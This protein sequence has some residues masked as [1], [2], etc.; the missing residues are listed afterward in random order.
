MLHFLLARTARWSCICLNNR[1]RHRSEAGALVEHTL[2]LYLDL[3]EAIPVGGSKHLRVKGCRPPREHFEDGGLKC[4][5]R[6]LPGEAKTSGFILDLSAERHCSH[7][8]CQLLGVFG[9]GITLR[10]EGL[11]LA[12]RESPLIDVIE[13]LVGVP[14][15]PS[16]KMTL[17]RRAHVDAQSVRRQ[18]RSLLHSL[19]RMR[20]SEAY[21][22]V[23]AVVSEVRRLLERGWT[24]IQAYDGRNALSLLEAMTEASISGWTT[25]DDSDG[26]ASGFFQDLGPIWTEA[27]LS[28]DL[29]SKERKAWANKLKTWQQEIDDYG[30]E[31]VFEAAQQAARRGDD[32]GLQRMLQG[33]ENTSWVG[34]ESEITVARLHI[35]E[36]R[37]RL[38]EYL[39]LARAQGQHEASVTMLVRLGRT[40]EAAA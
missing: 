31:E 1:S 12:E 34:E 16:A 18:V 5:C 10:G 14:Q 20:S 8:L 32:S 29:S 24:L 21:W 30:V 22:H 15:P 4:L 13:A 40:Q 25:L 19:D 33:S 7:L 9:E 35:L 27:L 6:H 36:R 17:P 3:I 26:S 38:Q 2:A 28:A 37:G 11:D 39:H 23:G